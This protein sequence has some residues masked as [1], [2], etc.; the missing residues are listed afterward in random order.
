MQHFRVS[1]ENRIV[2]IIS[3]VSTTKYPFCVRRLEV[4]ETES[5][6]AASPE[7]E[8]QRFLFPQPQHHHHH[9][10]LQFRN[11]ICDDNQTSPPPDHDVPGEEEGMIV[12]IEDDQDE[13]LL[14]TDFVVSV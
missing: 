14:V 12:R 6:A 13:D 3:V 5:V 4:R 9:H 8:L 11:P 1:L 2:C 10:H 7:V